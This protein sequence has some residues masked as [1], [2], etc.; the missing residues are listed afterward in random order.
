MIIYSATKKKF[1]EDVFGGIIKDKILTAFQGKLGGR[2]SPSEARSY[3]NSLVYMNGVVNTPEI[4]DN[5]GVALEYRIPS[6]NKRV[7]FLMSG[8]DGKRN[9]VLVIVELKQWD[10]VDKTDKDGLVQTFVGGGVREVSHPSYQAWSYAMLMRDF[11]SSIEETG[12]TLEACAFLH[13]LALGDAEGVLDSRYNRYLSEAPVFLSTDANKLRSFLATHVKYGDSGAVLFEVDKGRI[14]PSKHLAETLASLLQGNQEFVMIDDQKVVYEN[15]LTLAERAQAGKKSV[16]I[17]EGGPGTGKSVVAINLLVELTKRRLLTH[18]VTKNSAPRAVYENRLTGTFAKSHISNLFKGSGI[19]HGVDSDTFDTLVVDEAHRLN[20][21][22]GLYGHLGENQIKEI[23]EAAKCAIF[24]IDEDQRVTLRD[25][26][27]KDSIRQWAKKSGALVVEME[28]AS[29][30][31]CNGS[32]AY[33]AWLDQLLQIRETA[34]PTLHEMD[35]D[36]RVM[37][38]ASELHA[39]VVDKNRENNKAR[40]VAGYCWNWISRRQPKEPDIALDNGAFRAQWNL[41][42]DG[43]LWIL[44]PESV[45]EV[46]CIHTCQGLELDHVGVIIGPDLVVRNGVVVTDPAQRARTDKSLHGLKK[47][48]Q[49]QPEYAAQV[50]DSIIKNT[51]RTLMTRGMRGCFVYSPDPETNEYL[52]KR[53]QQGSRG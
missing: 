52:M 12:V 1:S 36:F 4:P 29:Q 50:A 42:K 15:A 33:L 11:N 25:I 13:N 24:F 44:K 48:K 16:L 32:D 35:Y 20:E 10:Q 9:K 37:R 22:S 26:G 7:D 43:S 31:R 19:F 30:F 45:R 46:G 3:Q 49:E 51:Y 2:V 14:R 53:Q 8:E 39:L 41:A 34:N 40:T 17:V 23:I 27:S 28:L 21:K 38:S 6:T 18:Y 5:A 47:L